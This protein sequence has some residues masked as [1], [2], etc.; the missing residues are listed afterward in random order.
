MEAVK[1]TWK[2]AA[3]WRARRHHLDRR[4]PRSA[5]LDVVAELGG[6]HAQVLSS[7]ELSLWARIEDLE[8]EAVADALWKD[9]SLVKTWAM[10]GTLHLLPSAEYR[11]WQAALGRAR[12]YL[13]PSW[14]R[15]FGIT[16][17]E[18]DQLLEA[19]ASALD[20]KLLTRAEV[21]AAIVNLTGSENLGEKVAG[22]W[23][24]LLKPASYR[25][26][27]CFGPSAGQNVRFTRPDHWLRL[28]PPVDPE[29]AALEVTRRFLAA[30]GPATREDYAHWW[31]LMSPA[32][33]GKL[34]SELGDEV[35]AVDVEGTSSWLLTADVGEV[36]AGGKSPSRAVA[37]LPAFDQYVI[38]A[39]THAERLMV[40]GTR[41]RI[42]RP[43]AWLTPVLIVGGMMHG[44]WKSER[45]GRRLE[46]AV[47]P[48]TPL[49]PWARRAVDQEAERLAAF[50]GGTLDLTVASGG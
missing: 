21:T 35:E 42:Y 48:F 15:G 29:E 3:A 38:E 16:V 8:R 47:E 40:G 32:Q 11:M 34:I 30:Y 31:G 7:A 12:H 2:Q 41:D 26:E 39:S 13:A 4:V 6:V 28:G 9:R 36:A 50:L 27:L 18:R 46:V 20:G 49:P 25:G 23:G 5:L 37:L 19:V 1:L 17:E 10:R 22:S 33:A 24:S 44:V 14:A 43:Q 45:K